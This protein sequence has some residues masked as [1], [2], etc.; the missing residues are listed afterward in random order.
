MLSS[1][2]VE[3]FMRL[4]E[5]RLAWKLTFK[6]GDSSE[7]RIRHDKDPGAPA[8]FSECKDREHLV[9]SHARNSISIGQIRPVESFLSGGKTRE[10][11][12]TPQVEG[13]RIWSDEAAVSDA[14]DLNPPEIKGLEILFMGTL[15]IILTLLKP[16]TSPVD[17]SSAKNNKPAMF[18][19]LKI[20]QSEVFRVAFGNLISSCLKLSVARDQILLEFK[21]NFIHV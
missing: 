16:N 4:V 13:N 7:L 3:S 15:K 14:V 11:N 9:T 6:N 12:M 5:L 10:Q 19:Y 1:L 20:K 21:N 8:L 17:P 2:P 18:F